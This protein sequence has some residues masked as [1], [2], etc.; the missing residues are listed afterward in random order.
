MSGGKEKNRTEACRRGC[1]GMKWRT[2]I[3]N[4]SGWTASIWETKGGKDERE[5]DGEQG[6]EKIEK[7]K[8][9][10]GDRQGVRGNKDQKEDQRRRARG[11]TRK[12]EM[13]TRRIYKIL[14]RHEHRDVGRDLE[15]RR[16]GETRRIYKILQRHE[17]R[18]VGRDLEESR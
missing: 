3:R 6:M 18:D 1:E 12:E 11:G 10:K 8:N 15:R 2:A 9:T 17:H 5:K 4:K 16:A 13:E 14:Q 7:G